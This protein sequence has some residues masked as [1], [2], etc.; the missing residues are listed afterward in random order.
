M[1]SKNEPTNESI[2]DLIKLFSEG[3]N[4]ELKKNS[5]RLQMPLQGQIS[6]PGCNHLG[7]SNHN[8]ATKAGTNQCRQWH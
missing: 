8:A 7:N 1:N 4:I 5:Q 3:K 2:V 6:S